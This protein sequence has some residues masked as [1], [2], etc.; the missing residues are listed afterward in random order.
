MVDPA[1]LLLGV[2][3]VVGPGIVGREEDLRERRADVTCV[4][5]L[6]VAFGEE[7][8]HLGEGSAD[9]PE[10]PEVLGPLAREQEGELSAG[11]ERL[12]G[13]VQAGRTADLGALRVLEPLQSPLEPGHRIGRRRGHQGQPG[14]AGME[15]RVE[16]EG[17]IGQV[18][19]GMA[20]QVVGR[21]LHRRL[22]ALSAFSAQHQQL[23][24][25][26]PMGRGGTVRGTCRRSDRSSQHGVQ[27]RLSGRGSRPG[28]S[29]G[30]GLRPRQPG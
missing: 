14:A 6:C 18:G 19:V 13:V 15:I 22:Q 1:Q 7:G 24:V 2:G 25:P 30:P 8:L 12:A 29:G 27:P 20:T 26:Q 5:A 4:P 10:H 16:G 28:G 21:R 23:G 9:I 17:Q 11:T 3:E